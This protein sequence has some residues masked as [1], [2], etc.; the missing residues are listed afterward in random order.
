MA[1]ARGERLDDDAP[2][3][4]RMRR[5][6][7]NGHDYATNRGALKGRRGHATARRRYRGHVKPPSVR[8]LPSTLRR[9]LG[10]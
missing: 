9:L 1:A 4:E 5:R 3:F 2:M 7:G 6:L 10:L 8:P